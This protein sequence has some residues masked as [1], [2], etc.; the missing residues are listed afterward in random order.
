M[1]NN[2]IL[3]R[4]NF[5]DGMEITE[6]DMDVEQKAWHDSVANSIG[7][8]AGSGVEQEFS[9][10]RVLF[11][12]DDVPAS[13]ESL[14]DTL[15][16]DGEPVYSTDSFG[17]TVFEQPSDN[18]EG[19][20]LEVEVSGSSLLGVYN[21]KVYI[22]GIIYGNVFVHEVLTFEKNESQ[23]T[24]NYFTDIVAIMT[25]DYMGNQNTIVTG[26]ACRQS[27]GRIRILESTPMCIV[28]DP[29]MAEQVS[30]PN[31]DYVNFKPAI[32]SKTL[33]VILKE[34][35][36]SESLNVD[37]LSI[38]VTSTSNREL[39]L[40]VNGLIIG[41]KFR[42][43][44]DN[45]QK[46][47]ILLS[48]KE[49]TLAIP[50]REYY[51]SGDIVVGIRKLQ[52][53]TS[54]AIDAI[55]NTMIEFDPA[56]S[57]I[58]EASFSQEELEE[59]G[60]VL[61]G[62]P[63]VVDFVFTQLSIANP[64]VTPIIEIG[65]YYILTIRRSGNISTGTIVM[66]ESANTNAS[67]DEQDPM[68]MSIFSNGKWVDIPESDLWFRIYTNAIRITNGAAFD[69]GVLV[70]SPKVKLDP[71]TGVNVPYIEGKHP[72]IDVSQN[73]ENY[74]IVQKA[75]NFTTPIPHPS[76]GNQIFTRIEDAPDIAIVS[77]TTIKALIDSGNDTIVLGSA[78]D[79]NPVDNPPITG[80]T[81]FPGL[82]RP[83]TITIINPDSDITLNNLVRSVITPNTNKPN[84]RYR[85]VKQEL[86]QDAYGDV[87]ADGKIDL[88]DIARAQALDGYSSDLEH[89]TVL[90]A[91]QQAAIIYGTVNIEEIIRADVTGNGYVDIYDS[92]AIQQN[93]LLGTGFDA[94]STFNRVVLTVEDL[95][96]PLTVAPDMIAADSTFNSVPFTDIEYEISF[97]P[98]WSPENIVITDMRR[99]VSKTFTSITS[100]DI[101]NKVGG[102]NTSFVPGN[103]LL[104]GE[105]LDTDGTPY[106]VDLEIS[107]IVL[108]I[109]EGS[110]QGEIDI[111]NNFIRNNM[112][113]GDGTY[114]SGTAI[115]DNQVRVTASIQSFVKDTDGYDFASND[116]YAAIDE[117]I[118][119]LYTQTSGVLRIRAA[120]IRNIITRPEL[121]TKIVLTVYLKK[122]GFRNVGEENVNVSVV[123]ELLVPV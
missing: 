55:P 76:T 85:I 22:Y 37:D 42:A 20:Q 27:G 88:S 80:Y 69:D 91:A 57:E 114:V 6:T 1:S 122:A 106:S 35:A 105:I 33:D 5:F 84:L 31:M 25:Q 54:C 43:T 44:T 118:A 78:R 64:A 34:I 53:T 16:F 36:D 120:N 110:T 19:V 10:Q 38:N 24:R 13:I 113:F 45:I 73:S 123:Q 49:N 121:S 12:T 72:L 62:S 8:L 66:E 56:P 28:R 112:K 93:I 109:P 63:K 3:P 89:G 40:N 65:A 46:V 87:G 94:G 15:N 21:M 97:T 9:T 119:I 115:E 83:T 61:D 86:F 2:T 59:R 52:T 26:T 75:S 23:V 7:F 90:S 50:G 58:V 100:D 96:N 11:D 30:E 103:I 39:P 51:W 102:S 79:T 17:L 41:Q 48:V 101:D 104:G 98:S 74:V 116:G 32:M 108:N 95:L 68:R 117:T 81:Q 29:I 111:F 18:I 71:T 92:Q 82:V 4:N 70:V 67:P 99:F 14:M 47:S 107:T 77:E 60:V